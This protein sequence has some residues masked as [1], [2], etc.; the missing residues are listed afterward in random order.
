MAGASHTIL[1]KEKVSW[2]THGGVGARG[3]VVDGL[4]HSGSMGLE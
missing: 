2:A 3:V 1:L 4:C